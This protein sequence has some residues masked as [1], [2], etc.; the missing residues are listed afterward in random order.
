[1]MQAKTKYLEKVTELE[2]QLEAVITKNLNLEKEV[3]FQKEMNMNLNNKIR[4]LKEHMVDALV[5]IPLS[6]NKKILLS[7]SQPKS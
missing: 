7:V 2:L 6:R 3:E 5:F 4:N 1:M